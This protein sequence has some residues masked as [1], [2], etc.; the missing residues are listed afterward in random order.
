MIGSDSNHLTRRAALAGIGAGGL[1]LA[2]A[3]ARVAA[4]Q[5]A[6]PGA[7]A[8]H[9]LVGTWV[10]DFANGSAPVAPTFTSDGNFIDPGFGIA[11]VWEATGP[12]TASYVWVLILQGDDFNGYLSVTGTIEVDPS[13]ESWTTTGGGDTT[14]AADGTVVASNPSPGPVT[15]KRLHVGTL[16]E[17]LAAVPTWTPAP[18]AAA[19]PTS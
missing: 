18:P 15:A 7:T 2:L 3:A 13:G 10:L 6:T 17:P 14:V 16:G 5:D 8:G 9:P 11:G 1:G 12:S 4:A 19:T